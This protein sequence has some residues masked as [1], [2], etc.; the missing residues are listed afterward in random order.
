MLVQLPDSTGV[1]DKMFGSTDVGSAV[2]QY[3]SLAVRCLIVQMFVQLPDSTDVN[4]KMFGST[5]VCS[6]A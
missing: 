4:D 1:N 2:W 6:V 5:D 3:I